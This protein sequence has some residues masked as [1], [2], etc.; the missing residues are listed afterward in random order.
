[1]LEKNERTSYALLLA[2]NVLLWPYVV[3]EQFH[4]GR[5]TIFCVG[6]ISGICAVWVY[7]TIKR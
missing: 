2:S 5:K 1:M 7:R 3:L 4:A 6:M